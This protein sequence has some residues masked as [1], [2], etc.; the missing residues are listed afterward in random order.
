MPSPNPRP[1]SL[2]PRSRALV[3]PATP[4]VAT[5]QGIYFPDADTRA[6]VRAYMRAL[7]SAYDLHHAA[8]NEIVGQAPKDAAAWQY[9]NAWLL[10]YGAWKKWF[11]DRSDAWVTTTDDQQDA[12]SYGDRLEKSRA[13][14][15]RV[16]RRSPPGPALPSAP[17]APKDVD[18]ISDTT[19]N[20]L[21]I[22]KWGVIGYLTIQI[23][24]AVRK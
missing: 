12:A 3:R 18:P 24:G 7:D 5:D 2:F 22:L 6:K 19:G 21:G 11:T 8:V 20:V 10:L 17:E 23:V 1:K 9:I 13:E 16:F 4:P 14:F 15:K